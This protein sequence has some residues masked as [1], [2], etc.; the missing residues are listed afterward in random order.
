MDSVTRAFGWRRRQV[1]A[2]IA[3]AGVSGAALPAVAQPGWKPN[4]PVKLV[5]PYPAG[6]SVDILARMVAP[7]LSERVDQPV[8]VENKG[9]A[10]GTIGTGYVYSAPADGTTLLVG[11]PDALSIY[12]HLAKTSYDATKFVP[13]ANIG[14]TA[15]VLVGRPGLPARNLQEVIALARKQPLTFANAGA[16]GFIH[17]MTLAFARAA[18]IDKMVH[19]PFQGGAPARQ[20]VMSDQVDLFFSLVGGASQY[21]SRLKYFAVSSAQRVAEIADV[22]TFSEQGLPLVRELWVGVLAPPATPPAV[23][24]SLAKA[25]AEIVTSD[26]YKAKVRELGMNAPAMTQQEFAGYYADEYRN[27]GEVIRSA[28]VKLD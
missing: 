28:K 11:V 21:R 18:G 9:G 19:V 26:A 12:P 24:S 5:V 25:I 1:L 20:A 16:G 2:A 14:S 8:V 6:G 13:V 27:W 15:L 22:P 4:R 10:S 7:G 3:T 23:S 17:V